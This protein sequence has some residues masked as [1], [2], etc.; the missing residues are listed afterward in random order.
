MDWFKIFIAAQVVM[1]EGEGGEGEGGGEGEK[2]PVKTFTQE[3]VNKIVETRLAKE[4]DKTKEKITGLESKLKDANLTKDQR[5][6]FE[7]QVEELQSTL[8]TKDEQ[9][10]HERTQAANKHK[11]EVETLT[12]DRNSWR[13]RYTKETIKRGL[14]DAGIEQDAFN[15]EQ[16]VDMFSGASTLVDELDD[17]QKPTGR[18]KQ[19]IKMELPNPD[20]ENEMEVVVLSPSEF[21]KR[22]KE[23]HSDRYGNLFKNKDAGGF[24][25]N[26]NA[27]KTNGKDALKTAA[28]RGNQSA[29][30]EARRAQ[31]KAAPRY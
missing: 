10:E 9:I 8:R 24:G 29:Y 7:Q 15:P 18:L 20:K 23:K 25:G 16:I 4:R 11:K 22:L 31:R 1:F 14:L 27:N 17:D 5:D 13:E 28:T 19:V 26:P 3:D 12:N 21:V 2:P 6:A 30:R